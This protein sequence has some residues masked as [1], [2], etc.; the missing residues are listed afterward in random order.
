[1]S[2]VYAIDVRYYIQ[3][4]DENELKE[5]LYETGI[6][7]DEYYGGYHIAFVED[8]EEEEN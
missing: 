2:K 1:M 3:A 4:D 7:Y 8:D 6:P 5:T